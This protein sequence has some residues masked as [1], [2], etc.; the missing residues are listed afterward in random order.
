MSLITVKQNT[1][2]DRTTIIPSTNHFVRIDENHI[3]IAFANPLPITLR[4]ITRLPALI[5]TVHDTS[6]RAS[7]CMFNILILQHHNRRRTSRNYDIQ[8]IKQIL[9]NSLIRRPIRS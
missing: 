2:N 8:S 6:Y 4:S 7:I 9:L 3:R 5:S 1:I